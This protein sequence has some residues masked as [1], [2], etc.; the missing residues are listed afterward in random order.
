MRFQLDL[1]RDPHNVGH[2]WLELHNLI[3]SIVNP[4]SFLWTDIP[5]PKMDRHFLHQQLQ[6][7]ISRYRTICEQVKELDGHD[8]K[9]RGHRLQLPI[10]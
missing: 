6:V 5:A 8:P 10:E 2:S 7:H 1:I 3:Q 4:P 9:F